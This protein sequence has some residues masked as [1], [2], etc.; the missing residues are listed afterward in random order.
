M[1]ELKEYYKLFY[2]IWED[3]EIGDLLGKGSF[4]DVYELKNKGK[5]NEAM[6]EIAVPPSSAGGLTEAWFQGLDREGAKY[7]YEGMLRKALEEVEILKKFS[8]CP[9]IIELMDYK[10]YE[11]P[12][13]YEE[14]GWVIFVRMELLQSLKQ[15][16]F[17]DGIT[18]WEVGNLIIDLCTALESCHAA[19]IL[20][21]DI[22]PEN[23]FY[24]P[25]SKSFKLGD[26]GIACYMSRI[27]EEK[28]L[29]G[30]LTHMAPEIYKGGIYDT[31]ADLYAVGMILYKL[32]N[33]NRVPF[34]P[35]FPEKYTP[36]MRNQAIRHR[37][38][39]ERVPLPSIVRKDTKKECLVLKLDK[40]M[41][42]AAK[43]LAYIAAKAV[44][45]K[46]ENRYASPKELKEAL[47]KW[48]EKFY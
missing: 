25:S 3:C 28:G 4:G 40:G 17:K 21:R 29:P 6:K 33:E 34:L 14:Y 5:L 30:T 38:E 41:E 36:V 39:G 11:L 9:N 26:F 7:Y 16:I 42:N 46:K 31:S 8:K 1:E 24:S 22:K 23:I 12:K 45:C 15:K 19:G 20:H 10:I 37:L 47:K 43:E 44:D 18:L 2:P 13:D 48:K 27:T 32:L 35:D